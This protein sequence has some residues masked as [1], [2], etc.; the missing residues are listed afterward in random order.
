MTMMEHRSAALLAASA[1]AFAAP[2]LAQSNTTYTPGWYAGLSVGVGKVNVSAAEIGLNSGT[3]D[4][5]QT[6]VGVRVGYDF[7]QYIGVE[8]A[9]YNLGKYRFTGL[10]AGQPA[11]GNAKIDSYNVALVGSL[12]FGQSF[13]AYGKVGLART[14]VRAHAD[15]ALGFEG[16]NKSWENEA[17]YGVGLKWAPDPKWNVFAEWNRLNDTQVENW[18]GGVNLHF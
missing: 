10:F 3:L 17:M 6:S 16:S 7:S 1:L 9:Y 12:P 5:N 14:R 13:A 18:M 2:A 4:D 15:S 11:D 8:T